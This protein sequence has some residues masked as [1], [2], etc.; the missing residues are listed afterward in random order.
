MTTMINIGVGIA[1]FY[2]ALVVLVFVF[3]RSL[4]YHPGGDVA[5]PAQSG[6]P[7]AEV[8][9][10]ETADGLDLLAW[11]RRAPEP[12][13]PVVLYF[14]GNAGH[15]GNRVDKIRPFIDAGFGVLLVSYRGYGGNRG[16]PDE[17]GLY[18]DA[19]AAMAFLSDQGVAPGRVAAFGE[20]LGSAVAVHL[21]WEQARDAALGAVVLES[22]F[23]TMGETAQV[24]YPYLPAKWLVKDK[25]ESAAKIAAIGAPLLVLHGE[26]DRVVPFAHGERMLQAAA[27][28]KE[29][30]FHPLAGHVDL[31]DLGADAASVAFIRK[32]VSE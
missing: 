15:I 3:Q 28:P 11:W 4:M 26:L 31:F 7:E 2:A 21:A 6:A 32:W 8:V 25:Y 16:R 19:R 18:A 29:S 23:T 27:E 17:D 20:S 30:F 14:H 22:P 24:H 13:R 12:G 9:S 5:S 10:L 1:L